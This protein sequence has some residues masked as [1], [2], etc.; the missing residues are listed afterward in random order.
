[1]EQGGG[2]GSKRTTSTAVTRSRL[3]RVHRRQ[4]VAA[5]CLAA[6]FACGV[7]MFVRTATWESGARKSDATI[8]A[9][10]VHVDAYDRAYMFA[11]MLVSIEDAVTNANLLGAERTPW[12]HFDFAVVVRRENATTS[13]LPWVFSLPP[14]TNEYRV[15]TSEKSASDWLPLD[16]PDSVIVSGFFTPELDQTGSDQKYILY[17]TEVDFRGANLSVADIKSSDETFSRLWHLTWS[18]PPGSTSPIFAYSVP[19]RQIDLDSDPFASSEPPTDGTYVTMGVCPNCLATESYG[20]ASPID[21]GHYEV[22]LDPTGEQTLSVAVPAYPWNVVS[23]AYWAIL[24]TA[25]TPFP[26]FV[27]VVLWRR[28]IAGPTQPAAREPGQRSRIDP[29]PWRTRVR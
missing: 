29:H 7:W 20:D 16:D 14:G 5:V 26:I 23:Q 4:F 28:M 9:R 27:I 25:L 2:R 24:G 12:I 15:W 8:Y 17:R 6:L 10:P 19:G 11:P 13:G 3:R 22:S 18:A 1:M 21:K